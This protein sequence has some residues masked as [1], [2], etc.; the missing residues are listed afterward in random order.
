MTLLKNQL[1]IR[2]KSIVFIGFMGVGKTTVANLVA[3][4][5]YRDFIDIDE[6]I[7]KQYNMPITAI[8]EQLGEH[9]FRSKEREYVLNYCQQPLKVISLGG[10]AFMQPEIREACLNHSIVFYLDI[11]WKSWKERLNM[12]IDSRPVLQ[13]KSIEDIET[14]FNDRR[15]IYENHNS[16]LVTDDFNEE[17]VADYIIESIKLAWELYD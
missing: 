3:K 4:K 14:L 10:G 2:E 9:E 8:F 5:L 12:L 6:E 1:S 17:E 13:S 16:K 11:S 15:A 7:E